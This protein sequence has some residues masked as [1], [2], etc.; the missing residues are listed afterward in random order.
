MLHSHLAERKKLKVCN[1]PT[2]SSGLTDV[3]AGKETEHSDESEQCVC[4]FIIV[5]VSHL[6]M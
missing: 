4:C 3:Y 6:K 5:C 1:S 2:C